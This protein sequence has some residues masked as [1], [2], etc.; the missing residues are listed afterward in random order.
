MDVPS[1][2]L[3]GAKNSDGVNE[4]VAKDMVLQS[5]EE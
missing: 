5:G 2:V 1:G 4:I 3:A